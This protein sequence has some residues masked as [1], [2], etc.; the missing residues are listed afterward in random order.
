MAIGKRTFQSAGQISQHLIPGAYSRIDSVKGQGSLASANNGVIMGKSTGGKPAT[1]LQFNSIAE[2]VQTLKG[3]ALM[4]GVRLAFNPGNDF[5]PQ[6]VFAM[7]VNTAVVSTYAL[8]NSSN[9][10]ITLTSRDYGLDNN[11]LTVKVEAGTTGKKVT[12][13]FKTDSEIFDNC[14][15]SSITITHAT[16]TG[17]VANSSGGQT[18]T[19]SVG[20]I[21]IDLNTYATIGQLAAY[22]NAQSGYTAVVTAGQENASSLQLDGTTALSLTGGR[23]FESTNQAII[24]KLNA[25]SNFVTAAATNGANNRLL[26]DNVATAAYFTGGSEGTYTGTEW[27]AALLALEAED[28]QFIST[29]DSSTTVHAAISAH[30]TAMSAVTGRKERQFIV[31]SA[32]GTVVATAKANAAALNTK[33]GLQVYNGFTQR[34]VNGVVQNY[35]AS[36]AAC[37]LLGM[38]C[39]VAINEPLTF[40][41]LNVISLENKISNSNLETLI[42]S[43]VCPL[44]YSAQGLP[45]IV[46]QVNTYLTDDLKWNEFSCV[47]EMAFVSRDLRA[48]L[49][50]L[51]VGK[52]GSALY[53][54]IIRGAVEARLARYADLGVFSKDS[55]GVSWWNV[56]IGIAGDTVNIDYDAYI[57]APVNFLFI[58][59]HFHELVTAA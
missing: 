23:L 56:Q 57:T 10:I 36:Y 45:I 48:Y 41:T 12:I 28:V 51:F 11:Q 9:T 19:L 55:K 42:E 29:P 8:K 26:I 16:A 33:W 3:G 39:A 30:C 1:L 18:L 43:G 2:A 40:K 58:T 32:W 15:R 44:N 35:D 5:V 49:E 53:G 6:R 37:M 14:Y 25:A 27:T 7:R 52:P 46:R 24:D 22:I 17:T 47:K 59:N 31:G 54:G 20:P 50:D 13:G 21:A 4:E 34:D 38:T